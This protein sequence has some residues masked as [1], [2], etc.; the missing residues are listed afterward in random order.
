MTL[1]EYRS[2]DATSLAELVRSG[3]ATVSEVADTALRSIE[4]LNAI[5]NAVTFV[6]GRD[7]VALVSGLSPN[8]PFAGAPMLIK[9]LDLRVSGWPR[10]SGSRFGMAVRDTTDSGLTSLYRRTGAT[11]IGRSASSEM[12]MI[13]TTETAAY[14]A[15]RNPWNLAY[16]AGG[17][18]GGSA[19]AVACGMVPI[20]HASDGLGS[21]RIPASCCGVIG[22]KPTRGR[23]LNEPLGSDFGFGFVCDHIVSR[24]VRDSARMLDATSSPRLDRPWLVPVAGSNTFSANLSRR[25]RRLKIR[26]SSS[27]AIGGAVDGEVS[28][29]LE[30]LAG[31]LEALGHDVR[32]YTLKMHEV[33]LTQSRLPLSA[34]IFAATMSELVSDVGHPPREDDLEALTAMSFNLSRKV[35][36]E[37]VAHSMRQTR[38]L[39]NGILQQFDDFDVYL[40]PVLSRVPAELGTIDGRGRSPAQ[41]DAEQ[42]AIY[43]YAFP[44]NFTGQPSISLPLCMSSNGLPIGMMFTAGFGE[45]AMLIGLAAEL[46]TA[47]PWA[48]RSPVDAL[49]RAVVSKE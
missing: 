8:G 41:T 39:V 28:S 17:S 10:T 24:T 45:E 9:D 42:Y 37:M 15:T 16:S 20:A 34:A 38:R 14:G 32:P 13:G 35:S 33:E 48:G 47:L 44:F 31:N 29:A 21:I 26:W 46:E 43:P 22:L 30:R 11:L 36:A 7:D 4:K 6:V 40:T 3:Q 23:V 18:S 5:V 1:D 2:M 12:G 49:D 25:P 19:A 27:T